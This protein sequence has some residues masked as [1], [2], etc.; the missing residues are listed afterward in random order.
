[1]PTNELQL[2]NVIDPSGGSNQSRV[3]VYNERLVLSLVR[4]HGSLPKSE[5]ARR[6]GLSAQTVSVIMRALE[7]E[8]LLLR[9]EPNRGRVGQP[10]IPMSLNP[11]G[12]YSIGLKIGRRSADLVLVDFLGNERNF[13]RK[14]YP[15]PLPG[16]ILEFAVEAVE[17]FVE[18]IATRKRNRIAGIGISMPF[19]L[20][21]WPEK[22]DAPTGSMDAWRGLDIGGKLSDAVGLPV[23]VQNDATCACGAELVFG[24]GA[25]YSDFVYF[26][27]AA[28]AGGGI[29]LNHAVY[30]GRTGNAG[31][32]GT[33]PVWGENGSPQQLIDHASI[34]E[35]EKILLE[36]GTDPSPIWLQPDHWDDFEPAIDKWISDAAPHLAF[37]IASA[38]SVIDFEAAVI[39]GSFPESVK[40]RLIRATRSKLEC[41]DL[42][43]IDPPEV[44]KG[45]VGSSARSLGAA[46]LPLFSRFL[47]DQNVLFKEKELS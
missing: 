40:D 4:R 1:M 3:R 18:Q 26:F 21:N 32:L 39:D 10:S 30:P 24:R 11:D 47:L 28:F 7:A 41:L 15:Y 19:G 20:W 16:A 29:V 44:V 9:G 14:T 6:T 33:M 8:G 38:C 25:Q 45:L 35:L 2:E 36:S 27:I 34:H 23:L 22:V 17:G 31:A 42:Q 37:A 12:A 13:V 46:G 5:I 43:G